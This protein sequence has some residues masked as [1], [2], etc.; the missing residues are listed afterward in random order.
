MEP[1]CRDLALRFICLSKINLI[2]LACDAGQMTSSPIDI[3][4]IESF[5]SDEQDPMT[6]TSVLSL[7]KI[8]KCLA[9]HDLMYEMACSIFPTVSEPSSMSK[10]RY[11]CVSSAHR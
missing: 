6:T 2:F 5:E 7:S 1:S 9:I 3:D 10:V 8:R 4:G 11:S